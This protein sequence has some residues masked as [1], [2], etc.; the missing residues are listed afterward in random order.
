MTIK[1]ESAY[2]PNELQVTTPT[3]FDRWWHRRLADPAT[4]VPRPAGVWDAL[5]G[6]DT[7]STADQ[8]VA[9]D[10]LAASV[11]LDEWAERLVE[12]RQQA[13]TQ[14]DR[15]GCRQWLD[16]GAGLPTATSLYHDLCTRTRGGHT[17][18]CVDNDPF[19]SDCTRAYTSTRTSRVRTAA[20]TADLRRPDTML[21]RLSRGRP[22]GLLDRTRPVT[23]I[24]GAVLHHLSDHQASGLLASI[25]QI[26]AP[27]SQLVVTHWANPDPADC[28]LRTAVDRYHHDAAP[29]Y[30]RTPRQVQGL[31]GAGWTLHPPGIHKLPLFDDTAMVAGW[32]LTATATTAR[33]GAVASPALRWQR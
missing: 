19:I 16:L 13:V 6:G 8:G 3:S 27:G 12:F 4:P 23:V 15:A 14:L 33:G 28:Q 1:P 17:L 29:L 21:H 10:L 11:D 32:G 30:L 31:I 7:H 18:V 5:L 22:A 25:R 2:I 20:L 26:V 9:D 24:A